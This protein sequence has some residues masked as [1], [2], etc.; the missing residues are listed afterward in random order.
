VVWRVKVGGEWVY[1]YLLIEFQSSVDKYMALRMMVYIGLLYQDLIKRGEV[2]DDGRLPPILPIVLYNGSTRWTSATD[3]FDLIP[4]VP[5]LVEQFK[6]RLKYLLIDENSYTDHELASA[7][8]LVAA[9]FRIE[10]PDSP[11]GI[12]EL[13]SLLGV[14][15]SD[16]PDLRRMFAIWIRAT[17]MRKPEYRIVLPQIDDLQEL[18]VMLADRLEE[19]ALDYEAQG[20]KKGIQQGMQE[21]RQQGEKKGEALALQRL[22]TKRFG[23]ISSDM[24]AR[25]ADASSEQIELWLDQV[26]EANSLEE[27]FKPGKQ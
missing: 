22:L 8:N 5:G 2:L 4:A 9:V 23:T 18:K 21:G 27:L 24:T 14:W 13:I 12:S 25:I 19:W 1:L 20:M 15:L 16:R 11:Q 26:L 3:I 17:L 6:P 7:K 10:H